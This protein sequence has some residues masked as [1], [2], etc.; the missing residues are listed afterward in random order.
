MICFITK[1]FSSSLIILL[2]KIFLVCIKM[3]Y[4]WFNRQ[5]LLQKAKNRYHNCGGKGRAAEYYIDNKDDLKQ[6]QII[7][8]ETFQT[9]KMK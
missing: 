2:S 7:T 6:V 3:S 1:T 8:I 5:E 9:K 4:H